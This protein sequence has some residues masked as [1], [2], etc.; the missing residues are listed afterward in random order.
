MLTVNLFGEEHYICSRT[1]ARNLWR[2]DPAKRP[3][4]WLEEE[5]GKHLL[6]DADPARELIE[7]KR[8]EPGRLV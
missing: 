4:L 1:E 7:R 2:T 6:A 3:R 5:Y 8:R